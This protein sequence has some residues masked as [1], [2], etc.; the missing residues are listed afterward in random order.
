M[1]MD[2]NV[3]GIVW[4]SHIALQDIDAE[5]QD[6]LLGELKAY[7]LPMTVFEGHT[8]I[9]NYKELID[10]TTGEVYC[11]VYTLPAVVLY[12]NYPY[13]NVT[14]VNGEVWYVDKHTTGTIKAN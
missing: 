7:G 14:F 13:Y 12:D 6:K 2:G 5:S 9:E 1:Q 10:E 11:K 8:H 3:K 4:I